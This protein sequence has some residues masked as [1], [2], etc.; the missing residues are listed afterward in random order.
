MDSRL[1]VQSLLNPE[2]QSCQ[3]DQKQSDS[4]DDPDQKDENS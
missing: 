4:R 1:I 2:N 3:R